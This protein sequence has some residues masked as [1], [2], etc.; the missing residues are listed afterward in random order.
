MFRSFAI[1]L[2]IAVL[3][4]ILQLPFVQYLLSDVQATVSEWM[5]DIAQREER[6]QLADISANMQGQIQAMRP[7]QQEYIA[8]ILSSRLQLMQF[9]H[10]YCANDDHN[11]YVYGATLHLFCQ[12]IERSPLSHHDNNGTQLTAVK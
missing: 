4:V 3:V 8:T 12:E 10:N 9:Y 7:Y 5:T 11:P 2:E 6:E 1:A